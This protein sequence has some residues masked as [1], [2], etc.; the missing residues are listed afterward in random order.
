LHPSETTFVLGSHFDFA[1]QI[2]VLDSRIVHLLGSDC[3]DRFASHFADHVSD[4]F[5]D[6]FCYSAAKMK[7]HEKLPHAA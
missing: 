5:A 6:H 3:V 7:M 4:H 2:F 1:D